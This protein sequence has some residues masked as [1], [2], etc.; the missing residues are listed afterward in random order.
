MFR[1]NKFNLIISIV[2]AIAIWAF[3]V[4][5][6]NPTQEKT[7]RNIPVE[8]TNLAA[9][10]END[11]TVSHETVHVVDVKI[12]GTRTDVARINAGD[13]K[14][15]A[16]MTGFRKGNN[17]VI[18]EVALPSYV[19][20]QD[21]QPLKIEVVVEDMVS[22]AKAVQL[23]Y[24]GE[25]AKGYEAGFVTVSPEEVEVYGTKDEVSQIA[26][27]EAEIDVDDLQE[28]STE[29]NPDAVAVTKT[30]NKQYFM[31]LSQSSVEVTATLCKVKEV[32][33]K[34]EITG[35]PL[36]GG[37]VTNIDIPKTV[38]IRCNENELDAINEVT[39]KAIDISKLKETTII[40][41]ELNLPAHIELANASK[42][43]TV[44]VSIEGVETAAFEYTADQ[45]EIASPSEDLA[46]YVNTGSI[47]VTVYG[48]KKVLDGVKAD[49]VTPYVDLAEVDFGK[50]TTAEV[51]VQFKYKKKFKKIE[52]VPESVRVTIKVG[53][54]P[55]LDVPA[56]GETADNP[57][58]KPAAEE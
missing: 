33:L 5:F 14:A 35:T 26:Y 39:G 7:F 25:L 49:D 12:S 19:K 18:V 23:N 53:D 56:D 28:T 45:I 20:L 2:A 3:V 58:D 44:T 51:A 37:E 29:L 48:S 24:I 31:T 46:A 22:V 50:A 21:V 11:L 16:D 13:I 57:Q 10:A 55:A 43:I 41:P 6:V 36:N 52:C 38:S 27:V 32:P 4:T 47:T 8:L 34:I 17:N 9:L 1:S 15:T 40:S 54:D 30:G 42:D